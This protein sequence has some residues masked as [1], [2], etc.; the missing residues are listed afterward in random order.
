MSL[1]QLP[2]RWRSGFERLFARQRTLVRF[3]PTLFVPEAACSEVLQWAHSSRLAC[4]PGTPR[5]LHLLRKDLGRCLPP[6]CP[7]KTLPPDPRGSSPP[8]I[9]SS[10]SLVP[11]R[12]GFYYRTPTIR[13]PHSGRPILQVSTL[14]PPPPDVPFYRRDGGPPCLTL[15]PSPWDPLGHCQTG[16]PSLTPW[17]GGRSAQPSGALG[18]PLLWLPP[19]VKMAKWRG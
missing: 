12:S 13:G 1:E 4:H 8:A 9:Y 10:M 18:E 7:G 17:Y 6:V 19:A 3:P 2:D 16:V 5:T 15:V 14:P 11:H